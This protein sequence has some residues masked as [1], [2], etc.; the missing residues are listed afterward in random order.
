MSALPSVFTLSHLLTP[1]LQVE[2]LEDMK[3]FIAEHE[4]FRKLQNNVTKHI[5]IMSEIGDIIGRRNLMEV[6]SVSVG[7]CVG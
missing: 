4:E 1:C 2:S 7:K 6:S 5:N 3:R